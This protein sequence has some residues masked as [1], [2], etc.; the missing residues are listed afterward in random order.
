M[1]LGFLDLSSDYYHQFGGIGL[2]LNKPKFKIEINQSDKLI[3]R[4]EEQER[5]SK[6]FNKI[7]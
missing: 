7:I 3:V 2:A 4:G 5:V 1:H 6:Y